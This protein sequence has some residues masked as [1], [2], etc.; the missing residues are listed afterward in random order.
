GCANCEK[1]ESL[2]KQA[3][4]ELG[5]QATFEKV[6]DIEK[7]LDYGI[8]RTPGLVIEELVK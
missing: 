6:K 4:S 1:L 3:V 8:A 7:I 5:I 2:A